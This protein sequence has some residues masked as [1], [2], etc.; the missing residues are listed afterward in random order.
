V[1][2]GVVTPTYA[3]DALGK[4]GD[5]RA[6]PWLIDTSNRSGAPK[7][8]REKALIALGKLRCEAAMT[9]LLALLDSPGEFSH[10]TAEMVVA[11][12]NIGTRDAFLGLIESY[13]KLEE[14][15][16]DFTRCFSILRALGQSN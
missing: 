3:I 16:L 2:F 9:P 5:E 13:R 14:K 7:Y 6:V 10:L 8:Q 4:L 1:T 12:A 15:G 11:L